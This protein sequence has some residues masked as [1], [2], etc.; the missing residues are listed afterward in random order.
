VTKS[1]RSSTAGWGA[2]LGDEAVLPGGVAGTFSY[3]DSA[4]TQQGGATT[5]TVQSGSDFTADFNARLLPPV[6]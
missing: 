2:P 1:G 6:V 3:T 4:P 5:N